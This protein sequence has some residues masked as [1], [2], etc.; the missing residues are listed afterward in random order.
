MRAYLV[1]LDFGVPFEHDWTVNSVWSERALADAAAERLRKHYDN[2]D[3]V[4][5]DYDVDPDDR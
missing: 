4:V 3:I 1:W 2:H 5:E